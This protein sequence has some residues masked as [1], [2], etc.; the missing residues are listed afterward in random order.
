MPEPTSTLLFIHA[1]SGL[2][3]GSGTAPGFVDLP[4]QRERHTQWPLIPGSSLKGIL[5][6]ACREKIRAT[7][8][9]NRQRANEED[10]DLI[11][12]FGPGKIDETSAHSG[13]LSVTD[14]RILAFPVRSLKGVFAWVT[15]ADVLERLN[16]DLALAGKPALP[17]IPQV[18]ENTILCAPQSPLLIDGKQI[19]LEEFEFSHAGDAAMIADW[20]ANYV[21]ADPATRTRI[22]I[23]LAVLSNNEFTHFVRYATEVIARIGLDYE[24]KTVKQTALFYQELL[25]AETLF[26]AVLLAGEGRRQDYTKTAGDV[27]QYVAT[28]LPSVLQIGGNETI[29]KGLCAVQLMQEA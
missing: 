15:C 4:V 25:P 14:A 8:Q 5:R 2:H 13:A 21:V 27:L 16:R 7:Y 20:V 22:K 29:G 23:H 11:S 1:L 17:H 9:G 28:H 26:Y 3:P 10:K 6:D 24:R 19:L 18:A 12:V